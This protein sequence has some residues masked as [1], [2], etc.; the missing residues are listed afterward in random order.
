MCT[1]VASHTPRCGPE[2]RGGSACLRLVPPARSPTRV[3]KPAWRPALHLLGVLHTCLLC[4]E[5]PPAP[6]PPPTSTV[7]LH[8]PL[9]GL[10]WP[11][12]GSQALCRPHSPWP[13]CHHTPLSGNPDFMACGSHGLVSHGVLRGACTQQA[14]GPQTPGVRAHM[15]SSGSGAGPAGMALRWAPGSAGG[16]ASGWFPAGPQPRHSSRAVTPRQG[17]AGGEQDGW[18]DA[19]FEE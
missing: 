14:R 9:G 18:G 7:P 5:Q 6:P 17:L 3:L 8:F 11:G 16:R 12:P 19:G 10:P 4:K 1:A 2:P 13:L 15:L